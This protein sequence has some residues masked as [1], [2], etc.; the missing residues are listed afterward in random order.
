LLADAQNEISQYRETIASLRG[1]RDAYIHTWYADLGT[2]LTS[3]QNDLDL[4][5]DSLDKDQKYQDLTSLDAPEDAIVLKVGKMSPGSVAPGNGMDSVT[6][7]TDPLFTLARLDAQVESELDIAT[8]DAG[9]VAVGDP[10]QLKFDTYSYIMYGMARG[11]VTSVS[12]GSFSVDQNNTPVAP[13]FKVRVKVTKVELHD[14]PA[15][16]RVMPGMTLTGDIMIGRRTIM[17][18][19]TESLLKQG[20]ETM[21]EPQ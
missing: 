17:S 11:V 12:E 7:G 8:T 1:Q 4:T 2:Q 10:V 19:L 13:Y 18:Y 21:R 3:D 9:F 6:P 16:F 5:R 14:V 20:E 15:G